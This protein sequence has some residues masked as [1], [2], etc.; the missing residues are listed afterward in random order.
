MSEFHNGEWIFGNQ[1]MSFGNTDLG[2]AASICNSHVARSATMT[3]PPPRIP[4]FMEGW[5]A[6]G[7]VWA[8]WRD[9]ED[10]RQQRE[11]ESEQERQKAFVEEIAKGLK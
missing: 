11:F 3:V 2:K 4:H 6:C 10:S 5:E 8:A 9:S 1:V 7:R